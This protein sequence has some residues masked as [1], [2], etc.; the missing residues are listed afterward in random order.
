MIQDD[1]AFS[2]KR[3]A[4]LKHGLTGQEDLVRTLNL[5]KSLCLSLGQ[6]QLTEAVWRE[7]ID[8]EQWRQGR[9]MYPN[10]DHAKKYGWSFVHEDLLLR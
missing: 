6:P 4:E 8:M 9:F 7:A 5:A 3:E 10:S 1:F 2:R